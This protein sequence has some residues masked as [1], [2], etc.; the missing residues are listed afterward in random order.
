MHVVWE[1]THMICLKEKNNIAWWRDAVSPS[2]GHRVF[3]RRCAVRANAQHALLL[4]PS[5]ASPTSGKRKL[6]ARR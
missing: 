2:I 3:R 6:G 1:F 5:L 4:D